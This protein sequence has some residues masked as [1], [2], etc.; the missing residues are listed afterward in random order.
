MD[1]ATQ[2]KQFLNQWLSGLDAGDSLIVMAVGLGLIIFSVAAMVWQKLQGLEHQ[3]PRKAGMVDPMPRSVPGERHVVTRQKG[4]A[5][6]R[7][8]DNIG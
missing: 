2:G 8:L 3:P 7:R 6:M 5:F 1:I 4:D